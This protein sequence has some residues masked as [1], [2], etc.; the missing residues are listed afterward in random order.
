MS[1]SA[2]AKVAAVTSGPT[3]GAVPK[4]GG[5]PG[6][7]VVAGFCAS[8]DAAVEASRVSVLWVRNSRRDFDMG[9]SGAD[10]S[11]RLGRSCQAEDGLKWFRGME[12][13]ERDRREAI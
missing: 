13:L 8:A 11:W 9:S 3:A 1:F 4:A 12:V 6:V 10:C 5:A 2:S 7:V